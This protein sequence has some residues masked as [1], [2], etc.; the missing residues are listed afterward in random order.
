MTNPSGKGNFRGLFGGVILS[1]ALVATSVALHSGQA[2]EVAT[3]GTVESRI[4]GSIL[5]VVQGNAGNLAQLEGLVATGQNCLN[6]GNDLSTYQRFSLTYALAYGNY[7]LGILN[8]DRNR[9]QQARQLFRQSRDLYDPSFE[10]PEKLA[11]SRLMLAWI[12][13]RE[14]QLTGAVTRLDNAITYLGNPADFGSCSRDALYLRAIARLYRAQTAADQDQY[15]VARSLFGQAIQDLQ[16]LQENDAQM[17]LVNLARLHWAKTALLERSIP[18]AGNTASDEAIRDTVGAI[19][20]GIGGCETPLPCLS[21]L[22]GEAIDLGRGLDEALAGPVPAMPSGNCGA[23]EICGEASVFRA[24]ANFLSMAPVPAGG[25]IEA[26]LWRDWERFFRYYRA[27]VPGLGTGGGVLAGLFG[28]AVN[29]HNW[30]TGKLERL[31]NYGMALVNALGCGGPV[32]DQLPEDDRLHVQGLH[33]LLGGVSSEDAGLLALAL[34]KASNHGCL[35]Q[36]AESIFQTAGAAP[37]QNAEL[38]RLIRL[39]CAHLKGGAFGPVVGTDAIEEQLRAVPDAALDQEHKVEKYFV[40]GVVHQF[41]H[42]WDGVAQGYFD[43]VDEVDPRSAYMLHYVAHPANPN[44]LSLQRALWQTQ[45]LVGQGYALRWLQ[46][47]LNATLA[48]L[49][50]VGDGTAQ[51]QLLPD[52]AMVRWDILSPLYSE[53]NLA[54]KFYLDLYAVLSE[55]ACSLAP[56]PPIPTP[57]TTPGASHALSGPRELNLQSEIPVRISAAGAG[58]PLSL[59]VFRNGGLVESLSNYSGA[60][61][62]LVTGLIYRIVV[63]SDGFWPVEV[64][65]FFVTPHQVLQVQLQPALRPVAENRIDSREKGLKLWLWS[66]GERTLAYDVMKHKYVL[67]AD[68]ETIP[69]LTQVDDNPFVEISKFGRLSDGRYVF[70]DVGRNL[71]MM[72][73]PSDLRDGRF[74]RTLNLGSI[75]ANESATDMTIQSDDVYIVSQERPVVTVWSPNSED[76]HEIEAP[77]NPTAVIAIDGSSSAVWIADARSGEIRIYNGTGWLVPAGIDQARNDSLSIPWRLLYLRTLG[78]I[79]IVDISV[80]RLYLF[81]PMGEYVGY[82]DLPRGTGLTYWAGVRKG[83]GGSD[84]LTVCQGTQLWDVGLGMSQGAYAFRLRGDYPQ[85][86]GGGL[87][88]GGW[89][90]CQ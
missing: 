42:G 49:P 1:V 15:S 11:F 67:K 17:Y 16:G 12:A 66:D 51:P 52:N 72:S 41:T 32:P 60:E 19:S 22:F 56:I 26:S 61:F 40:L 68:K 74:S 9:L 4:V 90:V 58:G 86:T 47:R 76:H 43:V 3:C 80:D 84:V 29:G 2:Q 48:G 20:D 46:Q 45:Q 64:D 7:I 77:F 10:M 89:M 27:A 34:G 6:V 81:L 14:Y 33:D 69:V 18:G 39:A 88:W 28:T 55:Y 13:L 36:R 53:Q 63:A 5:S 31:R 83:K 59:W 24:I 21:C 8:S 71:L 37:N 78:Y 87:V 30:R 23:G 85:E 65:T 25:G 75:L 38:E 35:Y 82:L 79:G 62:K 44:V 73:S 57:W 50:P 70:L 54:R